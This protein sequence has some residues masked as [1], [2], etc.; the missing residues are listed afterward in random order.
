MDMGK[1]R[2][3][4]IV[5]RAG[6]LY[7]RIDYTDQ[8]GKRRELMRRAQNRRH[9]RELKKQLVKQLDSAEDQRAELDA[10]KLTF[11]MSHIR[12]DHLKKAAGKV[13]DD[14]QAIRDHKAETARPARLH[15]RKR[16]NAQLGAVRC[17]CRSRLLRRAADSDSAGANPDGLG[18]SVLKRIVQTF[19]PLA[20]R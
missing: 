18:M 15:R 16:R 2:K 13:D 12:I 4:S 19:K 17:G 3:G 14:R 10:Q 20:S 1:Q 7:V 11:A 9:A 5:E 8:L 6:K